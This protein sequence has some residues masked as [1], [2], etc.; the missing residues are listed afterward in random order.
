[1]VDRNP[2]DPSRATNSGKN[3]YRLSEPALA[4]IAAF[5]HGLAFD[6]AVA[7]FGEQFGALE[8]TYRGTTELHR[9]PLILSDGTEVFLSAGA[10]NELQVA[11][12]RDFGPRFA[13]GARVLC[14][15]DT[16]DKHIIMD[17]RSLANWGVT[18]TEHDKLPDVVLLQADRNWI[19]LI[20]SRHL[21]RPGLAETVQGTRSHLQALPRRSRVRHR[22]S[23][24]RRVP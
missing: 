12:V 15:G 13:P 5:G 1:L 4:V 11:V 3:A 10:H 7:A 8:T 14:L 17:T 21:A 24:R 23:P 2:D 16:A 22:L 9:V 6:H 19:F 18:L 20:E